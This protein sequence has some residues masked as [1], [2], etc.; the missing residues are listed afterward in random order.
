MS[1]GSLLTSTKD[2]ILGLFQ[3]G[4]ESPGGNLTEGRETNLSGEKGLV[5]Q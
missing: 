1:L 2:K 5:T 3:D 4:E